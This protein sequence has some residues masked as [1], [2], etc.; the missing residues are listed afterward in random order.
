MITTNA[1]FET[2]EHEC[3]V[4]TTDDDSIVSDTLEKNGF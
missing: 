2:D 3:C 1:S 4:K